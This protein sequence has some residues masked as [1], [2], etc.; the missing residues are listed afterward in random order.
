MGKGTARGFTLVEII[1][2][3]VIIS[4]LAVIAIPDF[5]KPRSSACVNAG[6]SNLG[7]VNTAKAQWAP[8]YQQSSK[9]APT[10]MGRGTGRGLS[11]SASLEPGAPAQ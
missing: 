7:V 3:V 9:R 5:P 8:G 1:I 6:M 10:W 2:A 4:L 11:R